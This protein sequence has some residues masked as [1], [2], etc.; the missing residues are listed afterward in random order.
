MMKN[1]S[2][3]YFHQH[4]LL[5][6][7][8]F[9][10]CLRKTMSIKKLIYVLCSL[11]H[12]FKPFLSKKHSFIVRMRS[13]NPL[14]NPGDIHGTCTLSTREKGNIT[15]S[16][17]STMLIWNKQSFARKLRFKGLYWYGERTDF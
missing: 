7:M 13:V 1:Q 3:F 6:L 16:C 12:S 10:L 17:F 9:C 2:G 4:V 11:A 8:Y 15:M 5:I 14:P